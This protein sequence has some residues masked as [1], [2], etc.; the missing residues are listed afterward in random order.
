MSDP[1]PPSFTDYFSIHHLIQ[2]VVRTVIIIIIIIVQVT[3]FESGGYS[4][5]I[6]CSILL[7]DPVG[8]ATF[9]KR[10][11]TIHNAL[12]SEKDLSKLPLFYLQTLRRLSDTPAVE[13]ITSDTTRNRAGAKIFNVDGNLNAGNKICKRAVATACMEK[14]AEGRRGGG[15]GVGKYWL[16]LKEVKTESIKIEACSSKEEEEIAPSVLSGVSELRW[17]DLGV[18]EV[19]F[20]KGNRP[21]HVSFWVGSLHDDGVVII[22]PSSSDEGCSGMNVVVAAPW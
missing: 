5:G 12:L 11:A 20:F 7:V 10:W 6:S 2:L 1:C 13:L 21:V 14:A 9:L 15:K 8:M 18:D 16:L 17:E 19:G 3:N 4:I 22:T